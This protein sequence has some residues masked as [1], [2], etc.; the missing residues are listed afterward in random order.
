[1]AQYKGLDIPVSIIG[2]GSQV[3]Q[4]DDVLDYM[5]MPNDMSVFNAPVLMDYE[6]ENYP[7]AAL[8][9]QK[10]TDVLNGFTEKTKTT[11][12]D[13]SHIAK[14]DIDFINKFLGEGEVAIIFNEDKVQYRVQETVLAGVWR[15]MGNDNGTIIQ[16]FEV[17][18]YPKFI[19]T[20]TFKHAN[21]NLNI[22]E[23]PIEGTINAPSLLTE[24]SDKS[25]C[26]L[27]GDDPHVVNLTLLPQSPED[28][29]MLNNFL[30]IGPTLVLS[31]GYG[32]C[33]VSSTMLKNVWWVQY[34]NSDD[35]LILNTIEVVD[36]PVVI[37]ASQEDIEDS[38]ERLIEMIDSVL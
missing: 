13:F 26:W 18:N 8:V 35:K 21:L 31:R 23:V 32:S 24:L 3:S 20:H 38:Q 29:E 36:I 30:M 12:I 27:H 33:R 19:A 17:G 16:S 5:S 22:P 6:L 28:L 2:P 9:I 15:I 34:F 25:F 7:E 4:D 11:T 1:M 14:N 10:L 37:Q